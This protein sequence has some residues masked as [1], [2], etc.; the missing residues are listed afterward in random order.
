MKK[1]I[2]YAVIVIAILYALSKC[3]Q[4][5]DVMTEKSSGTNLVFDVPSLLGKSIDDI[6]TVLGQPLD[7]NP[8][9]TKQQM[10]MNFREWDNMFKRNG[11]QLLVTFNPQNRQVIDF[12][13]DS[14]DQSGNFN[15]YN[16]VMKAANLKIDAPDYSIDKVKSIK[17]PTKY[18]GIII[19]IR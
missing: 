11:R 4:Q 6:R 10:K 8:E 19:K 5:P 13:L 3:N 1:L 14:N 16:D 15:D 18:T 12:F 2:Y 17:D 7:N 9:P